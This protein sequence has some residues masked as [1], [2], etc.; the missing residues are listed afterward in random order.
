MHHLYLKPLNNELAVLFSDRHVP[1]FF[2]LR[3]LS[4]C[5]S[6]RATRSFKKKK[7]LVVLLKSPKIDILVR[8]KVDFLEKVS[9]RVTV[10]HACS[11]YL[12]LDI[13]LHP[14]LCQF[15]RAP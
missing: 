15:M 6:F 8:K 14:L 5:L 3:S 4:V 9:L 2:P 13:L 12:V 11:E 7:V 10:C 1:T